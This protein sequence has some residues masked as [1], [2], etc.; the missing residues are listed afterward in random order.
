[1]KTTSTKQITRPVDGITYFYLSRWNVKEDARFETRDLNES[2]SIK[3]AYYTRTQ[4]KG[5]TYYDI[6][7]CKY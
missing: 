7:V 2:R 5:V 4:E 6:R 3:H 1:M